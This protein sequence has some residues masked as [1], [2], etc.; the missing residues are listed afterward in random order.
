MNYIKNN[1]PEGFAI[2]IGK[3]SDSFPTTCNVVF[4]IRG[5]KAM[6]VLTVILCW[7]TRF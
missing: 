2:S 5:Q 6:C 4:T 3:L 7:E 1:N